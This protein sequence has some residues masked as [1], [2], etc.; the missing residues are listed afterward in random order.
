MNWWLPECLSGVLSAAAV[1]AGAPPLIRA[2]KSSSA[3][4]QVYS[5]G[6]KTHAVKSGTPTMGGL[7]FAAALPIALVAGWRNPATLA[8]VVLA[9]AC[10]AIGAADDIEKIRGRRT[11]GNVGL[12]GR[13]KFILTLGAAV[14]FL[15]LLEFYGGALRD[16]IYLPFGAVFGVSGPVALPHWL[17]LALSVFVVLGTTHA[18]NL[19]DGLDGLAAG[20][21]V[22]PLVFFALLP[23]AHGGPGAGV[24]ALATAGAALGFLPFN[25][26]PAQIF[27]G[28]TGALLLGGVLAGVSIVAGGQLLLAFAGGVLVAET[29]S[30][31]IQV[32]S[33]KT[34]RKRVFRMSPLHHHFE[35]GGWPETKVTL[36]FWAASAILCAVAVL[37][38]MGSRS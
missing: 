10:G 3:R 33:F 36:R 37:S 35:L 9:L 25:R 19:T 12:R 7:L 1:Y 32:V 29:V 22:T 28:D 26:Y 4:Q 30:V 24:V 8:V 21:V 14:L 23:L 6:P 16:A 31:I 2:L 15:A 11:R 27:M 5:D 20:T 34:T 38:V 18:V 17:W 13:V